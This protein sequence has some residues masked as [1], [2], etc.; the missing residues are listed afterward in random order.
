M[1][2]AASGRGSPVEI[3][4]IVV[5]HDSAE[6][7]GECLR[8]LPGAAV[9]ETGPGVVLARVL[10]VDNASGDGTV[11]AVAAAAP[12]AELVQ[13]G[14]NAGYA[15]AVNAGLERC[16]DTEAVLVLNPDTRL[17]PGALAALAGALRRPGVGVAVPRLVGP[18]GTLHPSL[19]REPGLLTAVAEAALG[20]TR[21][22]A[23]G[24]GE[25]VTDPAAY[26]RPGPADWATGAVLLISAA[27][28][29]AVGRWD[30]SFL[31]YSE[32]TDFLLR[33]RDAGLATW[34]V[35]DA[36][37]EHR[38]G[39]A[40]E[41]PL[42][43]SLLT[44]NRTRLY[45]RRHP[46]PRAAA[47][48]GAVLAG[49]AA[50]AGARRPP[51][52]PALTAQQ[53]PDHQPTQLP[54]SRAGATAVG[55]GE[56]PIDSRPVS[57]RRWRPADGTG[58]GVIVFAGQDWWYHNR[59]HS[60]IQLALRMARTSRVLLINSIGTRMPM[61]GRSTDIGGRLARKA[62]SVAR[63]L[64]RP[65]PELADFWVYSP[66]GLPAYGS[67]LGRRVN[68]LLVRGQVAVA[69]RWLRLDRPAVVVTPPT[70]VDIV[71][72]ISA[73][74]LVFNRSDKH[75]SWSE[76][77]Q[78][79]L[80]QCEEK[81][82]TRADAVLYV[83]SALQAE[84]APM[85]GD[86]AFFL[87]HGV[88]LDAFAPE[89][90]VAAELAAVPGPRVGYFGAF[91]SATVD[92]AL[93]ERIAREVPEAALVLVGPSTE[94]MD[95]LTALPN[96]HWFGQQPH[97]AIPAFGRGFDVALMPW[98]DNAWIRAANPI[99]MKEY[100]ALG[101]RVVSTDFPEVHRYAQVIDIAADA[102]DFVAL[103]RKAV[104]GPL[105]DSAERVSRR[106]A[107]VAAASWDSRATALLAL[108]HRLDGG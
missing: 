108:L 55:G 79:Y 31:L 49:E 37:V 70:A 19:R 84:D 89:G 16:A 28:L 92:M 13:V 64:R 29:A 73:S 4:V 97:E 103:V 52:P 24:W 86:R 87:D 39:A 36:V 48:T 43:W 72:G 96:V 54:P 1:G 21:A 93:L 57:R 67:V 30:E 69:A 11:D 23:R 56:R 74:T 10:V 104:G 47:F 32:E 53:T 94:P 46:G 45:R 71:R 82:L 99:K 38:G 20:G 63:L 17:R 8:A 106:R 98:Q 75:S 3:G 34:Y 9:S 60:D 62:R 41:S 42:L 15:A 51:A 44:V 107:A 5:T 58:S 12:D 33:A 6:V 25:L 81:L 102:D 76:V 40:H 14:R 100:L 18:D 85:V 59:A 50:G 88:D 61:P 65:V 101:R 95:A 2:D 66:L 78:D 83:S 105:P 91:R 7:V 35:P 26:E 80:R 77:D 27:C 68:R 22:A 90:P